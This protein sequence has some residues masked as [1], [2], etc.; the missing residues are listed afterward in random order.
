MIIGITGTD[1]GGKGAVVEYL[2][3]QKGFIHCSARVLFVDEIKKRGLEVNRA[4]TRI[5]AN[6]MRAT[7]GD[8]FL[9]AEYQRRTGFD[10]AKNYVV[11]SLRTTA[12]VATLKKFGGILW[13]VDADKH[14]RYE[15]IQLRASGTDE[16]S[17]E[18]FVAHEALEMNDPDPHG[19]QKAK[20]IAAAD[21]IFYN[22]GT[23][24]DLFAQVE[25]VLGKVGVK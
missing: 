11:E 21:H 24:A 17:F 4:N 14:A 19:M 12:E 7:H 15:R 16:V 10:T 20:V 18:E 9:I 25:E 13:A 3:G 8:D 5:V 23:Q 1:G 22:N 6:D 2:V